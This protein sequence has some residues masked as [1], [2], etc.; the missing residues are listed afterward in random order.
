MDGSLYKN[1]QFVQ[2]MAGK[3]R[4]ISDVNWQN[5]EAYCKAYLDKL[6]AFARGPLKHVTFKALIL[7]NSLRFYETVAQADGNQDVA[8]YQAAVYGNEAPKK[9][10]GANPKFP[11]YDKDTLAAYL[12]L[13]RRG[14]PFTAS[15]A[16]EKAS[17]SS[18]SCVD[19][20]FSCDAFPELQP[21]GDDKPFVERALGYFFLVKFYIFIDIH[22]LNYFTSIFVSSP[23]DVL[24][25]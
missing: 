20:S 24:S 18:A 13:P 22:N 7:F 8:A 6:R 3:L 12:S 15:N 17:K 16:S 14:A 23:S 10:S 1:L 9:K 11:T 2:V 5:N 19:T 25:L 4:P 21:I